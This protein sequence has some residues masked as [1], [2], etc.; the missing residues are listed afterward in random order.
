MNK[1][2]LDQAL[3]ALADALYS[4]DLA[5]SN[6]VAFI[7]TLPKGSL[8]GD[9]ISGGKITK[10]KSA[11]ITDL[12]TT[13]Q[14]VVRDDAVS[15]KSISSENITSK[16]VT[17]DSIK[18][19]VLTVNE[20][21]TTVKMEKD[22]SVYFTG[23]KIYS[24]GLLWVANDYTKQFVYNANPDRFFSS[25]IIDVHKGKF[26]SVGGVKVI[27][28]TE[29]G[30][31]I[32]KSNLREV[33]TLK[34][35][36]VMGDVS[37]NQYMFYKSSMDRLGLGTDTPHAGFSVAEMGIEVMLG[38]DDEMKGM[39]GTFAPVDFNIVSDNT[40]RITI[41]ATGNIVL[42]NPGKLVNI[43]A[44]V[45]I[46]VRT[47]DQN[48]DLHVAGPVRIHNR[49]QMYDVAQPSEG[50]FMVGDIV[51]NSEPLAGKYVGW[52]CTKAGNPGS[53]SPF[54]KIDNKA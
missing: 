1:K 3:A 26:F 50:T 10:F 5:S 37:I 13:E 44:K 42:G 2:N 17:A 11:G 15:I 28:D 22:S 47:V 41:G 33:G 27:D 8:S 12:S 16:S 19:D 35:L 40:A 9:L 29:I 38:T 23:D 32:F 34:G 51:W 48:V 24:K 25:E 45:G 20:I 36:N 49:L 18:V 31:T 43:P 7:E 4:D 6:P 46:G 14:L 39:V 52:I 53:W 21:K 54:G 30:P